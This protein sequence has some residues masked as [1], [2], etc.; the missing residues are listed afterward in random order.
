MDLQY[1]IAGALHESPGK[2]MQSKQLIF[3]NEV[4]ANPLRSC[5][6]GE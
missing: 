1:D 3:I 6:A 5:A 2:I 4:L